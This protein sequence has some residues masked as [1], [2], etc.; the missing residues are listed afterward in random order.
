MNHTALIARTRA[1]IGSPSA[2]AVPDATITDHINNGYRQITTRYRFHANMIRSTFSTVAGTASYPL[3]ALDLEVHN[4]WNKTTG[5]VIRKIDQLNLQ[6]Y[7]DSVAYPTSRGVPTKFYRDGS[8]LVLFP[9]P[10]SVYTIEI[11]TK[12]LPVVLSAGSDVP[13]IPETWHDCLVYWA[14]WSYF[15]SIGDYP[16]AQYAWNTIQTW[17]QQR[18]S[19]FDEESVN[20]VHSVDVVTLASGV[21]SRG[22][23]NFDYDD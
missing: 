15:D 12:R 10:D 21:N 13:V 17:L 2:T 22:T 16:K 5:R 19:E 18:P 23:G 4:V 7:D 3:N 14:R 11:L 1:A 6:S 20:F 8:N 9:N